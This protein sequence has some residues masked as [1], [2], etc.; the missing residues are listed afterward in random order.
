MQNRVPYRLK[1]IENYLS[2]Y[3][4]NV[5]RW[6]DDFAVEARFDIFLGNRHLDKDSLKASLQYFSDSG[7]QEDYESSAVIPATRIHRMNDFVPGEKV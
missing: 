7:L 5:E 3:L 6:K 1:D 2:L 4:Q